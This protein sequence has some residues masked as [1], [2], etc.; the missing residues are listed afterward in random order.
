MQSFHPLPS[1]GAVQITHNTAAPAAAA[2]AA[3]A[4]QA[5]PPAVAFM[6][7]S[8]G[9]RDGNGNGA[10]A[11]LPP[12]QAPEDVSG[13]GSASEGRGWQPRDVR[14]IPKGRGGR[15]EDKTLSPL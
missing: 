3:A 10:D 11:L 8:Q 1:S 5:Q 13:S 15:G 9:G 6:T 2:A 12:P 14:T 4:E 7:G